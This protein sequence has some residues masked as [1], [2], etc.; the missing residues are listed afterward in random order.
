MERRSY[1][2]S[3]GEALDFGIVSEYCMFFVWEKIPREAHMHFLDAGADMEE[4]DLAFA[5]L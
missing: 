5:L 1:R 3:D 2:R 4:S